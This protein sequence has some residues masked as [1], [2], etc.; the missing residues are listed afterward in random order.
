M[1][2]SPCSRGAKFRFHP[3]RVESAHRASLGVVILLALAVA[4][5]PPAS[6]ADNRAPGARDISVKIDEDVAGVVKM[7]G[8]DADGDPLTYIIVASP[9]HGRLSPTQNTH[10]LFYSPEE[11]YHGDD[12]FTYK[13]SDGRAESPVVTARIMVEGYI[14]PPELIAPKLLVTSAGKPVTVRMT[15]RDVDP[16]GKIVFQVFADPEHGTLQEGDA[17]GKYIYT[18]NSNFDGLDH[19]VFAVHN[20]EYYSPQAKVEIA[21]ISSNRPPVAKDAELTITDCCPVLLPL[22]G[23]DPDGDELTFAIVSGVTNG[24]IRE[25]DG[26]F[27]YHPASGFFGSEELVFLV[28][29]GRAVTKGKVRI[30]VDVSA[31]PADG[32]APKS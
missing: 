29:D 26:K 32:A 27:Y 30:F 9:R 28:S 12:E 22:E 13:V 19:V 15:V 25:R 17:P 23:T 31:P 8:T 5:P 18:P 6:A 24:S 14:D 7:E 21:V 2:T 3:Q 16:K 20:K 1:H 11:N 4:R 10:T